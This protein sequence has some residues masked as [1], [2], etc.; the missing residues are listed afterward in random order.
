MDCCDDRSASRRSTALFLLCVVISL[1]ASSPLARSRQTM[2]TVA[3]ICAK[4]SAV[5]F[6]I[7]ELAPVTMQ[8]FPG[9]PL[10]SAGM[11]RSFHVFLS[12]LTASTVSRSRETESTHE[13]ITEHFFCFFLS[14]LFKFS[15]SNHLELSSSEVRVSVSGRLPAEAVNGDVLAEDEPQE[16]DVHE[17]RENS[18]AREP[19]DLQHDGEHGAGHDEPREPRSRHNPPQERGPRQ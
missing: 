18:P 17:Q 7:P 5:A 12:S 8:F 11:M 16:R 19:D 2:T 3:P 14:V 1:L 13:T 15:L 4:A 10:F 6:P 9:I